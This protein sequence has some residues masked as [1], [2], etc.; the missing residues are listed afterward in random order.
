MPTLASYSSRK[1]LRATKQ[2]T[3]KKIGEELQ[4]RKARAQVINP[5]AMGVLLLLSMTLGKR[6]NKSDNYVYII[7]IIFDERSHYD[8]WDITQKEIKKS[9]KLL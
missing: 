3:I 5:L 8:L 1:H 7:K 9:G 6:S 4:K 2:K